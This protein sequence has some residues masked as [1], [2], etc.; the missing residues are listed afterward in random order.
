MKSEE[1]IKATIDA[2][3]VAEQ[4]AGIIY[5]QGKAKIFNFPAGKSPS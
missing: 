4:V 2:E 3:W 5:N 1:T